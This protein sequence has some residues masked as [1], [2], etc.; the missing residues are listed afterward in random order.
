MMSK[1]CALTSRQP[2]S[3]DL[4]SNRNE[5]NAIDI[6]KFVFSILVIS[7][8]VAP[9]GRPDNRIIIE[10]NYYIQNWFA[11]SAVPFFFV[12]SGFFLYKKTSLEGFS[13]TATK[14]YVVKLI[15]LYAVWTLIYSPF[16]I[17]GI[18][19]DPAG[20][21][22]GILVYARD[23]VFT[24]SYEHLWYLPAL[25]FAVAL[26]SF[27][28]SRGIR[29]NRILTAAALLY[30]AGL[31]AQS[32]F[33][34]IEPLR[35][36]APKLWSLLKLS[37]TIIGTTRN[38]LFEGFFFVGM[39]AYFAFNGFPLQQKKALWGILIFYTLML[40]EA[41]VVRRFD[42]ARGYDMYIFLV[43]LTWFIFGFALNRRIP[44]KSDR[45]KTLRKM[46]S[47][48][49]YSH[50]SVMYIAYRSFNMVGIHIKGTC[51]N[52][53]FTVLFSIACSFAVYRLSQRPRFG[54]LKKL[55]A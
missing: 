27:L 7:I 42:L 49:Y 8:H 4:P 41:I 33:G 55:Y 39:G 53:V 14:T 36:H 44:R 40:A 37:S 10:L 2:D 52:F 21:Q 13:L 15:K 43:P 30:A 17:K 50:I 9:L 26:V 22:H 11:R 54:W 35:I 32:W 34:I 47:L 1:P 25:V 48:I 24:S 12:S 38:G 6:A 51:W 20:V 19:A 45:F 31:L 23:I 3:N 29:L 16:R 5:Y 28:L 18:L 46:S